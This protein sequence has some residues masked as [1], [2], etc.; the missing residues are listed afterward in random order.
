MAGC[1]RGRLA[2]RSPNEEGVRG[3]TETPSPAQ[4]ISPCCPRSM[5]SR[6]VPTS[7]APAPRV[8]DPRAYPLDCSWPPRPSSLPE[9]ITAAHQRF[10]G[11]SSREFSDSFIFQALA[12]C[13]THLSGSYLSCSVEVCRYERQHGKHRQAGHHGN[14]KIPPKTEMFPGL[15][16]QLPRDPRKSRTTDRVNSGE[17]TVVQSQALNPR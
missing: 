3:R 14:P 13:H 8:N 5:L 16:D 12:P 17:E 2:E 6:L 1:E 4:S 10:F 9:L 7:R 11:D 15:L